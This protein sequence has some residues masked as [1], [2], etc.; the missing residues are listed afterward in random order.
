MC[1]RTS[2]Q[3]LDLDTAVAILTVG[4]FKPVYWLPSNPDLAVNWQRVIP[5][6]GT[7]V[8]ASL[9]NG[10]LELNLSP[11]V[12]IFAH[13]LGKRITAS[14]YFEIAA[15][16]AEKV[17]GQIVQRATVAGCKEGD[18]AQDLL[19]ARYPDLPLSFERVC[20]GFRAVLLNAGGSVAGDEHA[21]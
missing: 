18:Q 7:T 3:P 10:A 8:N 15:K 16:Y 13:H 5:E 20:A 21:A 9:A 11:A 19:L 14:V 6:E 12:S 17:A 4:Q 1:C 2:I